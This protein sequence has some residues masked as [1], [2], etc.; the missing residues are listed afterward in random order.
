MAVEE[1]PGLWE[2]YPEEGDTC[3]ELVDEED[4]V[5]VCFGGEKE[6]GEG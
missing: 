1:D 4:V 5:G 2:E 3:G 6:Q